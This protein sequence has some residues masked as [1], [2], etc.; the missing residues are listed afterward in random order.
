MGKRH[1]CGEFNI[2]FF[3]QRIRAPNSLKRGKQKV[4]T[5]GKTQT[6]TKGHKTWGQREPQG[7]DPT[8]TDDLPHFS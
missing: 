7:Q 3:I 6:G 4:S 1:I 2:S 8:R 5:K